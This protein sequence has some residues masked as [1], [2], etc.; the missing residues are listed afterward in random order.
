MLFSITFSACKERKGA[1]DEFLEK[2][3]ATENTTIPEGYVM[4][5]HEE[6]DTPRLF[7]G[8]P[9]LPDTN[10]WYYE[11]GNHGWGNNEL[12]NYIPG[13]EG[14]D[15][16][17]MV[18][19]GT[20]KII[21]KKKENEVISARINSKESWKYGYFE[22]RMKLP[23]GKGTWPAFWMMPEE[24]HTWP[25]DGEIDIM[26]EVG[27][28]PN[29]V[30]STIHCKAYYHSIGTQKTGE[31]YIPAAQDDFHVY[32]VEWTEDYIHGYVDGERYFTFE[33][34]KQGNKDTWPFD[35]PFYLKLNLAWGGDWGGVEGVDESSL[36]AIF[37]I[38][39]IR[40][41]QKSK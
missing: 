38:D 35:T 22:G 27:Y 29:W 37:E 4:V 34:D 23:R 30:V 18:S 8:R 3:N 11:T 39:Y 26:E 13:V 21:L 31:K 19:D 10:R 2:D 7:G 12:Q 1:T 33:N 25:D 16:C 9:A 36:P 17:V 14:T 5:W 28:R 24:G 32:S 41:F 40:V 6:F 15:T 20:L